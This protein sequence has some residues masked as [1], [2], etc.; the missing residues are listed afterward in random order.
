MQ[1]SLKRRFTRAHTELRLW[2][3]RYWWRTLKANEEVG[4]WMKANVPEYKPYSQVSARLLFVAYVYISI[5]LGAIVG[6]WELGEWGIPKIL[7]LF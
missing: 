7:N 4:K 3:W 1:V 5:V 6:L 2:P